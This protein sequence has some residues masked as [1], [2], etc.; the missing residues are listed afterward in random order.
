MGR[1]FSFH[2]VPDTVCRLDSEPVLLDQMDLSGLPV[3]TIHDI[4]EIHIPWFLIPF[5][6][7][8]DINREGK[9]KRFA[10][11]HHRV[12]GIPGIIPQENLLEFLAVLSHRNTVRDAPF[13]ERRE[14][15]VRVKTPIRTEYLDIHVCIV[16]DGL[17]FTNVLDL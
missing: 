1:G 4:T 16:N 2:D 9:I 8:L 6:E 11:S 15:I 12:T 14:H 3:N 10:G 5:L 7:V 13:L 17:E